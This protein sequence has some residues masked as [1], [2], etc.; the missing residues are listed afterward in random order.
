MSIKNEQGD[1]YPSDARTG[2]GIEISKVEGRV[3]HNI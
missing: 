3:F 1:A 2:R